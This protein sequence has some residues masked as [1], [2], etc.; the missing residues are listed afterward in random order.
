MAKNFSRN[1]WKRKDVRS[2]YE[3]RVRKNLD[4][5]GI[6]YG[7]ETV[8]LRYTKDRCKHCGEVFSTGTYT[9]DFIIE[10]LSGVRLVVECKGRFT[11]TDRTKM[12]RVIRDNPA[13]DIRLL[14]QRDQ[15]IRKG[16]QTK[17]STWCVKNNIKYDFGEE[18]PQVWI[19]EKA[20]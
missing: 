6:T 14:F 15:N 20:K 8:K 12:L 10:R 11:S 3:E 9:P 18:I 7:Y 1:I 17:Y 2:G 13:E 19:K 16:S 5:R 4:E